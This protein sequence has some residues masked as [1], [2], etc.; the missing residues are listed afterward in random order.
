AA[1]LER[2]ASAAARLEHPSIVR[3]FDLGHTDLGDPFIVMELLRGVS[4]REHLDERGAIAAD[5]AVALLLPIASALAAAHARGIVHRDIKP[6][7][8]VLI[9]NEAGGTV[10]KIVDFGIAK[11]ERHPGGQPSKGKP[12]TTDGAILGSPDYMS[13]EQARGD[14]ELVDARTDIWMLGVV[15]Y[16]MLAGTP[17]F[18]AENTFQVLRLIIEVEPE[19]L[20]SKGV[21]PGL[22]RI[23]ARAMTK[24]P[25]GRPKDMKTFGRMLA[26]WALENGVHTDLTGTNI[27]AHWGRSLHPS[28]NET[29]PASSARGAPIDKKR[30]QGSLQAINTGPGTAGTSRAWLAAVAL[31][32]TIAGVAIAF[33]LIGSRSSEETSAAIASGV[34]T[35]RE[36]LVDD[37]APKMPPVPP[38]TGSATVSASSVAS[39]AVALGPAA[40]LKSLFPKHTFTDSAPRAQVCEEQDPRRGA[41]FLRA[42]I[43]RLG[44]LEKT[45]TDAMRDWALLSWYE[46]AVF[47][48]VRGKCCPASAP[49]LEAPT[50]VGTC[51]DVGNTLRQLETA[52]RTNKPTERPLDDFKLGVQCLAAAKRMNPAVGMPYVYV[53]SGEGGAMS[54]AKR[55]LAR[56]PR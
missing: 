40:C 26:E 22:A 19:P 43:A 38:Q 27:A 34:A 55:I 13:P 3:I 5:K 10:P 42:E 48:G 23:V 56:A 16:E 45:T 30:S 29:D 41:L 53:D 33:N 14:A 17:P 12:R 25:A 46:M 52:A 8:I 49:P 36:N 51:P 1:R 7:N 9:E 28:F 20:E 15:L 32:F 54:A 24:H 44:T 50:S 11:V 2:E 21:D 4:L 18:Q 35:A 37:P 39:A 6:E 31:V 47:A